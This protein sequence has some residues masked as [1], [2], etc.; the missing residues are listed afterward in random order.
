M[1]GGGGGGGWLTK[2]KLF[3]KFM[4]R[5]MLNEIIVILYWSRHRTS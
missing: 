2:P 4:N 1:S 5:Q 3:R